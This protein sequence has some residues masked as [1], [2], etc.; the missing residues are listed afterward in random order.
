MKFAWYLQAVIVLRTSFILLIKK[1]RGNGPVKPWQPSG[2]G[3]GANS[4]F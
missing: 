3:K 1:G 4:N 2:S